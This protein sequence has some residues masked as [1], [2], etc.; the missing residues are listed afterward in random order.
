M[1]G[2]DQAAMLVAALSKM[3]R[4]LKANQPPFIARVYNAK[5]IL[6]TSTEFRA[7]SKFSR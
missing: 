6:I 2:E 4:I 7:H 1:K 5:K 3:L